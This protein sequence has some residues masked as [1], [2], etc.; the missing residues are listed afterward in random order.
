[1][2]RIK[3]QS[4]CCGGGGGARTA[5]MDFARKTAVKRIGEAKKTGAGAI[6]TSC[7]FCEQNIGDAL[8]ATDGEMDILDLTDIMIRA[9][10]RGEG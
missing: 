7:P 9:M 10:D 4:W 2:E 6:V 8:N 5:F 1:M 3:D